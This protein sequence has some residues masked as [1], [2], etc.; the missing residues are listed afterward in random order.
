[1]ILTVMST[2]A[3]MRFGWLIFVLCHQLFRGAKSVWY[4]LFL[5]TCPDCVIASPTIS[6]A[7]TFP[8]GVD[9]IAFGRS[10]P[11]R[12]IQSTMMMKASPSTNILDI[13][14]ASRCKLQL[15]S[16][17]DFPSMEPYIGVP[18]PETRHSTAICVSFS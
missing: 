13:S 5:S 11:S 2:M 6:I 1:M 18:S 7:K 10:T 12:P 17:V 8:A 14:R 16:R 9:N 4:C 15:A 3:M